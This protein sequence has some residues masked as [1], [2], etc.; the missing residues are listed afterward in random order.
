[1]DLDD[2]RK[3]GQS[4]VGGAEDEVPWLQ[5][6]IAITF[7]SGRAHMLLTATYEP[8]GNFDEARAA[9]QKGREL[10]PGSTAINV[11]P[12]SKNSNQP[13]REATERIVRSKIAVG[14][15]TS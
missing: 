2:W 14:F 8:I 10:R 9:M 4:P 7:A 12:L 3:L 13:F 1:M 15:P 5:K 11:P 6:S